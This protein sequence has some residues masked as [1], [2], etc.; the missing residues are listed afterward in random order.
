MEEEKELD[1]LKE[2]LSQLAEQVAATFGKKLDYSINS[3]QKVEKILGQLHKGY[4]KTHNDEGLN[5]LAME[6]A[7]YIVKVIEKNLSK[8]VWKRDLVFG[9]DTFP[10]TWES[11]EIFPY[12]WC[13]KRIFYGQGDDVWAKFQAL[14]MKK[15]KHT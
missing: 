4:K 6:F 11:K 7:A 3:V 10:Y 15:T 2:R 5:G 13:Q 14:L 9:K 12:S 8:G 1:D